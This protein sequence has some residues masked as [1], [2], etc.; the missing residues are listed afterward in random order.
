M[1]WKF[2]PIPFVSIF[3]PWA[4]WPPGLFR[5]AKVRGQKRKVTVSTKD[6]IN[7]YHIWDARRISQLLPNKGFIDVI[8]TSPPYWNLKDYEVESQIGFG[9]TYDQYL[10]D[11]EKVFEDIYSMTKRRGSLWIISDTIK[12][13]GEVKL[14]PFD[15][16]QRLKG[17][18][19]FLQDIVIWNKDRTLP[20]SHQ[21]RL[22]NIFEYITFYSKGRKFNYHLDRVREV[23][24]LKE[25]WVRYP[26]RYSPEGKAPARTWHIPIPRQGSWG[27]NWVRHFNPLPPEL[28]ERILL[29]TTD[30]EDIVLDP[31][32]GSGTVLAQAH[33]MGRKYIGLDLNQSYKEMFEQRVL[34]AIRVLHEQGRE[35]ARE[36]EER[37]KAFGNLIRS[38]R[39][40][41]YPKELVRLY[42][43]RH[44]RVELEAV[45]A[46]QDSETGRL[47]VIFLFPRASQIPSN[48]LPRVIELLKR[49]PLSKYGFKAVLTAHPVDV[50]SQGWL[51][52]KGL[53]LSKDIYVY[54]EGRTYAWAESIT[55]E[56]WLE[57]IENGE[58]SESFKQQR[59]PPI[60]SEIGVKV[61]PRSPFLS[62]EEDR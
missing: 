30:K 54:V 52:G 21:G 29:L 48:F 12:H 34:P 4:K 57:L 13:K 47:D 45:L 62:I 22:R 15:L 10:D 60:I 39:R 19:W 28:V 33:V 11:L 58:L 61:D 20:W 2:H 43:K 27:K 3:A 17:M 9:Q 26:E 35:R 31:F 36:I 46:L 51:K 18:G 49:P 23:T 5:Q 38:L 59:Y 16:A 42:R 25:W 55:V 7:E 40:I 24:E 14:L 50:V 44:G 6:L 1:G 41:K 32:C 8:I 37:K 56:E 53:D